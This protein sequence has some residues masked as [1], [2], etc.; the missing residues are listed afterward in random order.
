[1]I[2]VL[3]LVI[4]IVILL[5][6]LTSPLRPWAFRSL[7]NKCSHHKD[8]HRPAGAASEDTTSARCVAVRG[9]G[10]PCE[11]QGFEITPPLKR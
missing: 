4:A 2:P 1:M 10:V 3:L 8:D 5:V 7:C 6:W 9:R 11:C